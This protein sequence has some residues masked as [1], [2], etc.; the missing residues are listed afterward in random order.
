MSEFPC[1]DVGI[2]MAILP[3]SRMGIRD[4]ASSRGTWISILGVDVSR[5][6]FNQACQGI[7]SF[8]GSC[9][10]SGLSDHSELILPSVARHVAALEDRTRINVMQM[11]PV[12]A[13]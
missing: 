12:S 6:S 7:F 8:P 11:R 13:T 5:K 1:S 10:L 9:T 2:P 3:H 4:S